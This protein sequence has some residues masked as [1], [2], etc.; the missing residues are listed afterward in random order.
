[1]LLFVMQ[2]E[3]DQRHNLGP[4]RLPGLVDQAKHRRRDVVAIGADR[5]DRRP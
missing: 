3:L 4:H 2:A 1:M 5:I